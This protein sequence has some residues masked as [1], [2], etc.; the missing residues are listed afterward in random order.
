M[1][2]I[3]ELDPGF[4][5]KVRVVVLLH[6]EIENVDMKIEQVMRHILPYKLVCLTV[7]DI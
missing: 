6:A 2:I 4:L 7:Y 3:Y 5:K 1:G